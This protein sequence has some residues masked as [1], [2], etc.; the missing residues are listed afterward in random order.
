MIVKEAL[1]LSKTFLD[2]RFGQADKKKLNK[3]VFRDDLS[4][5]FMAGSST[6]LATLI[7]EHRRKPY[8]DVEELIGDMQ[9]LAVETMNDFYKNYSTGINRMKRI[10][11][12]DM[13][14]NEGKGLF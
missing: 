11:L 13:L 7:K 9:E 8:S 10:T 3:K 5:L 14:N 6:V 1:K 12:E 4:T 2:M